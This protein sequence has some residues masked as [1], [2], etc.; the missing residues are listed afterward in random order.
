M[1]A[2]SKEKRDKKLPQ[3]GVYESLSV[4]LALIGPEA[5]LDDELSKQFLR[6]DGDKSRS[7]YRTTRDAVFP[8]AARNRASSISRGTCSTGS[9]GSEPRSESSTWRWSERSSRSWRGCQAS[10]LL[11]LQLSSTG[12]WKR[13][14]SVTAPAPTKLKI[15]NTWAPTNVERS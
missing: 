10:N 13:T 4:W 8:V 14:A 12:S 3:V 1:L 11:R 7:F 2:E 9:A 6:K 5:C 15:I